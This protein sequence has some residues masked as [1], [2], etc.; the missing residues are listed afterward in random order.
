MVE[1]D[2][3]SNIGIPGPLKPT[4]DLVDALVAQAS[5][6][7]EDA[8]ELTVIAWESADVCELE[9]SDSG[10]DIEHRDCSAP[11]ACTLAGADL[12]WQNCPQ[13]GAAVTARFEKR[14]SQRKAA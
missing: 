2:C 5:R 6:Q 3:P 10:A 11:I 9:V 4:T 8:G 7:M 13:G 12:I 1:I 14:L